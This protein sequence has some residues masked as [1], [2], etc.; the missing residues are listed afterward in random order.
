MS[1]LLQ[2]LGVVCPACDLYLPPGTPLCTGCGTSLSGGRPAASSSPAA[3]PAEAPPGLRPLSRAARPSITAAPPEPVKPTALRAPP[4]PSS[5]PAP[6]PSKFGLR[7]IAGTATGQRYRLGGAGCMVGRARGAILF[8][9]DPHLAP[10]HATLLLRAGRLFVRDE[11]TLSGV[12]ISV[13]ATAELLPAGGYFSA[14]AHLFRYRGPLPPAPA[15]PPGRPLVYGAPV[16]ATQT[17]YTV[18]EILVG[19]RPGRAIVSAGPT[20]TI[21]QTG[22]DLSY[23]GD[24]SLAPQHCELIPGA[25]AAQLRDLS[26]GVGQGTFVRIPPAT[27]RLLQPGDRLRLGAQ[28]LQIEAAG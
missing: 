21:G 23:P 20:V 12:F 11:H 7:V 18:E 14:G 8:P 24:A 6:A 3:R 27:E 10:H 1:A 26:G 15:A 13:G 17:L 9:E 2:T 22:C 16:S 28:I 5:K 4:A 19:G 25:Q